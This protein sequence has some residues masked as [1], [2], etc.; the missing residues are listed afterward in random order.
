M[1]KLGRE[2]EGRPK[3]WLADDDD[4]VERVSGDNE[5]GWEYFNMKINGGENEPFPS[6]V[7]L[8]N[9]TMTSPKS[10]EEGERQQ[11]AAVKWEN[12]CVS[13]ERAQKKEIL[14]FLFLIAVAYCLLHIASRLFTLSFWYGSGWLAALL[15]SLSRPFVCLQIIHNTEDFFFRAILQ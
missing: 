8:N 12:R 7:K 1:M 6:Q 3:K 11:P 2:L 14:S 4:D 10:R 15:L 5:N 9:P 13:F